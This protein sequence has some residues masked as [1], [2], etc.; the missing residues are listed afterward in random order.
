[1]TFS[2]GDKTLIH[3][4]IWFNQ[5]NFLLKFDVLELNQIQ[6]V[7]IDQFEEGLI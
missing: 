6:F 1:M 5:A 7:L 4:S 2:H 3:Y